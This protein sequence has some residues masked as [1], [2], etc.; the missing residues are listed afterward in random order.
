MKSAKLI[1]DGNPPSQKKQQ[2]GMEIEEEVTNVEGFTKTSPKKAPRKLLSF[3]STST[4][5]NEFVNLFGVLKGLQDNNCSDK[6]NN[7][8]E[9]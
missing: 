4:A 2:T 1:K 8:K 9:N 7:Q 3:K 5:I 6:S